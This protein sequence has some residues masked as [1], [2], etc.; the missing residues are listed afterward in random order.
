[1][2]SAFVLT[3]TN[4]ITII[5]FLGV[6]AALGVTAE[7]MREDPNALVAGVFAGS[8][9]WW[10]MLSGGVGFARRAVETLYLKRVH[11]VSGGLLI[12][13]GVGVLAASAF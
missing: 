8:A 1:M 3:I 2:A 4:P 7:T 10:L 6:F 13:F 12:V 5:S 9:L 11:Y